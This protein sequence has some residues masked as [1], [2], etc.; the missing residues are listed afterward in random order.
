MRHGSN[1]IWWP[2]LLSKVVPSLEHLVIYNF[3]PL[4][5]RDEEALI[6][7]LDRHNDEGGLDEKSLFCVPDVYLASSVIDEGVIM[8]LTRTL[9]IQTL[10]VE[11]CRRLGDQ[12]GPFELD[13]TPLEALPNV[14]CLSTVV[15]ITAQWPRRTMFGRDHRAAPSLE[16]IRS[17]GIL[18]AI[19]LHT[20]ILL[21]PTSSSTLVPGILIG[22]TL[23]AV[24]YSWYRSR[25]TVPLPP[26]PKGNF[27]LG[28][29]L[30]I[31][32]SGKFWIK[33]AEY[34][35]QFGP[36]ITVRMLRNSFF[37]ISDPDLA[38][39]LY[40]KR[41]ANYSDKDVNEMIKL[42]GWDQDV[43][44]LP[45]GPKFKRF[46]TM[47]QRALNNRVALDYIPLQQYEV[48]R[49]MQRLVENPAGFME[50][51]HLM[52]GSIVVRIAYG[53]KVNSAD[54]RFVQVAEEVMAGFAD[55]M[56]PAK[57]A[58]EF[59]PFLRYLPTW[60]PLAAFQR[61]AQYLKRL[62]H[63]HQ[64]E[65]FEYTLKQMAEGTAEDSF[66]SKLLWTED[67]RPGDQQTKEDVKACFGPSSFYG[68]G[69]DTT[70][71]GVQS[72]FLAMTLYPEIQAKAQAEIADYLHGQRRMILPADRPNL[73]YTSA[74]VRELLR[75]HPIASVI[76]HQSSDL[77]DCNVVSGGKT[78]RIPARSLVVG[79]VWKMM[80]DPDVYPEPHQFKPERYL[81]EN[82]PPEPENYAFGFGRRSC[83]GIHIAQQSMWISVCNTLAN[84]AITKAMD[85]RG[86]EITP[87][88]RYTNSV[89]R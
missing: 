47:L 56:I 86:V 48:Q 43:F 28:N 88:E 33:F 40:E 36:I 4:E 22:G 2:L 13:N 82:P 72:F 12:G 31:R 52:A 16:L 87:E 89:I 42:I 50:H 45:Y 83:P 85:E 60:F 73:P 32:D 20:D 17:K 63:I 19:I 70:V 69:S 51:V 6:L 21:L 76:A 71:S 77:D 7:E 14:V 34:A 15:D 1:S 9:G 64:T 79:N 3:M 65:P 24:L 55:A 78:Y 74:L 58:V 75:W 59:F 81:V 44:F 54:D 39:E 62:D 80:H 57:W 11:G 84:F 41:A 27:L 38:R 25:N 18:A 29:I 8:L 46:R 30:E 53:Y 10:H 66:V 37:V 68:A 5:R 49:F 67:G 23:T 35:D 61:R 26:G